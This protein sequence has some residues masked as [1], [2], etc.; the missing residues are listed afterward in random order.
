MP[1]RFY[2]INGL[3]ANITF[4]G[5]PKKP[6]LFLIH[7]WMDMGMSF[8]FLAQILKTHFYCI[9]LDLRGFGK[10][11]H[12]KN[13]L[14]YHFYEY[15]ADVH[16]LFE[17]F[18]PREPVRVLGHSMGGNIAALYAGAFPE[19]VR[20]LVSIEGFGIFDMP[21]SM[22]P[23]ILKKWIVEAPV[24]RDFRIYKKLDL[25]AERLQKANP[26]LQCERALFLA[27]HMSR[28]VRGGF[29]ISADPKHKMTSPYLFQLPNIY[30]FWQSITARCLMV[31]G[32]ETEMAAW[33]KLKTKIHDEVKRRLE[34]FPKT[35]KSI[36]MAGVGHMLHHEK[37][38]EL[39]GVVREFLLG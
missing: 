14:G 27:K 5:N 17:I 4:W 16:G 8:E 3:K 7:G 28:R 23:A 36:T 33:L 24:R 22:G 34:Y 9:A 20:E 30:A 1:R 39:A 21:A 37:P 10:S 25:L 38:E 31:I 12:T 29:Q 35:T 18:S 15:L 13:P 6:K 26:R 11:A 2:N 19:R 32:E